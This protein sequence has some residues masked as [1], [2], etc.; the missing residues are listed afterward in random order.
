MAY[1][2]NSTILLMLPYIVVYG[3]TR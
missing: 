2:Y 1:K 3:D